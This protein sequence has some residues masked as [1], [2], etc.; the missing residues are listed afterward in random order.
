MG[1]ITIN[2]VFIK[3]TL[4]LLVNCLCSFYIYS[5]FSKAKISLKKKIAIVII[6]LLISPCC[7]IGKSLEFEYYR[8]A[9][10]ILVISILSLI[11]IKEYYISIPTSFISFGITY[12]IEIISVMIIGSILYI[13]KFYEDNLF[14]ETIISIF[15]IIITLLVMKIKRFQNG[16]N[17]LNNKNNFG[18]GLILSGPILIIASI[19]K[20]KMLITV[21]TLLTIG[22]LITMLGLIIWIRSAFTRYYRKRLKL[23][24]EEY[25]KLELAEKNKEI[26]RLTKENTSLSSI[27]HLDNHLINKLETTLDNYKNDESINDLI[28][29]SKQRNE[30]VNNKIISDKLLPTTG[31]D[32]V[33][34]VIS[35]MYIKTASRGIDFTLNVDCDINYL[36]HNII[37]Q[38]DFEELIR[39][40][41]TNSIVDIENNTD[42]IG[43]I[44]VKISQP[45]D[46]YEFTIMD[47]GAY[48]EDSIKS[49]SEIVEK[50]KACIKRNEFDNNDSFTKSLTIRFDG[51]KNNT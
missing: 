30:Y 7:A 4:E 17:F 24:A 13:F 22:M 29:L 38:P 1:N 48:K 44:L 31:N 35:D 49:I 39:K 46:I 25:S 37:E 27:I 6:L 12:G 15:R 41:I 28:T 32:E 8:Y 3:N 9:F 45:N 42:V 11:N 2:S 10:I 47:N 16:L 51:L 34:S 18:I 50:S 20:E 5:K 40:C 43:K 33:D 14:S 36:I 21:I 26:E 23:R 19:Y